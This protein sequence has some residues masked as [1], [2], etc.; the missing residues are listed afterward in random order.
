MIS[1]ADIEEAAQRIHGYG[2]RTPVMPLE[3][4]A[5]GIDARLI[6]HKAHPLFLHS[7]ETPQ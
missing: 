2:R 4:H 6:L 5:W 7:H 3:Q 1:R